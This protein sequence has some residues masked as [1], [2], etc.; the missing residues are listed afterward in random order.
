M[1]PVAAYAQQITSGIEGTVRDAAGAPL[2][3]A[4]VV[5]TDTR[6][7]SD[8]T[9]TTNASGGFRADNLVTGGP[10][11]ITVTAEGFEG[12][13]V[14]DAFINLQGNTNFNFDLTAGSGEIVVTGAR[15][16]ATQLAIGP[17]Q[18][19]DAQTLADFPTITRDIRDIIRFD[20]RVR[21]DRANEVDR[22]SCLGGNDRS[23]TFT[24]DGIVQSD[25][26]GLN[27]TPFAARNALPLPYDAIRET[28]VEFAPFDVQYGQ[29]TGC[30]INVVT[31][32]GE[33]QFHGSGF[34]T[35][36]DDGL[37]G[38]KID[39]TDFPS[40][41]FKEKRWGATLSGPIL[42]DRLFFFFGYEETDLADSQDDGP[43][44][45]G[46]PNESQF[47]T[48]GQ[49]DEVSQVIR[50][51]YGID[52]GGLARSLPEASQRYFGRLD[53]YINDDH[54]LEL[55]YQR[56]EE[57]N[58]E[59]DD[60]SDTNIT[61][62]NTFEAEGTQSN[63]YSARL[64][65]NWT[66]NFSTEIRASRSEVQDLQGPVGG[67]EAQSSNPI[68]R[69]IV[70]VSNGSVNGTVQA[71]PGFSRTSNDLETRISQLRVQGNLR[72]ADHSIT[73]GGEFNQL[74][75]FNLFGQ[76]TTGTLTF[77]N[78]ADLREGLLSGGASTNPN[79]NAVVAGGAA[80][81]Y[82]NFTASGDINTAAAE[83]IRTQFVAYAQDDW[84]V[85]P[86][87]DILAGVRVEWFDGDRPDA[88]PNFLNRY[89]FTNAIP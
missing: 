33:N 87:F 74:Y 75:V 19:F 71:G 66:E 31:K 77:A 72:Q 53:W 82:G 56:L 55:T 48:Q 38:K 84:Q 32:S 42:R 39:G 22:I 68:P 8:R 37:L 21:L 4:T 81:A 70:G 40:I 13:T 78:I 57:Q 85:T 17:G 14:E 80:G 35:Y 29:F 58:T 51:V 76:N 12:R 83:W 65:S 5:I 18:S 79:A 73:F 86:Q 61:G 46:Y 9:L 25:V 59:S 30:A 49:F 28:S 50:D 1:T 3:G 11:R 88:N 44:G 41:A 62:I 10:Y 43:A 60:F 15:A 63:Y 34:F 45:A 16:A 23:N 6:T 24:V 52:T 26:Y 7:G 2:P 54:R 67:G 89:G 36:T 69:I 27:G 47:V 64:F 20:P